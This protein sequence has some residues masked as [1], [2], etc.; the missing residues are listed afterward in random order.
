MACRLYIGEIAAG[1]RLFLVGLFEITGE[2]SDFTLNK[3]AAIH[4]ERLYAA[5][6]TAVNCIQA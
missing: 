5:K 1:P 6:N 4:E 3:L 2:Y